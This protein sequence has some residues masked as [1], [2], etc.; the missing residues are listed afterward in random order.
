MP[1]ASGSGKRGSGQKDVRSGRHGEVT[2]KRVHLSKDGF[3]I[4]GDL[5]AAEA[6]GNYVPGSPMGSMQ[7]VGLPPKEH[8]EAQNANRNKTGDAARRSSV[9]AD[10]QTSSDCVPNGANG[11]DNLHRQIDVNAFKNTNVHRDSGPVDLSASVLKSLP[12]HD[13]LAI[14]MILMQMPNI[15]LTVIYAA[16]TC[17]TFVAPASISLLD[18]NSTMPSLVTVFCMDFFFMLIWLFLWQP[19]Q[20]TI[21]DLA[22]PVIALT[23]GGG[24]GSRHGPSRGIATS[25]FCVLLHHLLRGTRAH[26]YRILPHLPPSWRLLG[27]FGDSLELTTSSNDKRSAYVWVRSSLAIHILT[28]GIVRFI[29]E[30]Y[31][32][33][34]KNSSSTGNPDPEAGRSGSTGQLGNNADTTHENGQVTLEAESASVQPSTAKKRKKQSALVRLQQPLWAALASTKIVFIKEIELSQVPYE[35]VDANATGIQNLGNAPFDK[36]PGKIWITYIGTDEVCF[37]TS[38]LPHVDADLFLRVPKNNKKMTRPA[39]VDATKPFYVKVNDAFWQPTRMSQIEEE[40]PDPRPG[41]KWSGDIYGLRPS[42][43]YVCEFIDTR[44]DVA[45]FTANIRTLKESQEAD[46]SVSSPPPIDEKHSLQ[47]DSPITTLQT[48]I[49]AAYHKLSEEKSKLKTWRKEW[50]LRVNTLKRDSELAENQLLSAGNSDEKYKQKIRQQETQK[51]QAER[52]TKL[53]AEKLKQL[54]SEPA[55]QDKKKKIEKTYASEKKAFEAAQKDMQEA[56]SRLESESKAKE[57]EKSNLNSRRNKVAT[58]I[59]KVDQE[60]SNLKD[61]NKRGVGEA[62]RRNQ[63]RAK[64]RE[65]TAEINSNYAERIMSVGGDNNAKAE[66]ISGLEAQLQAMGTFSANNSASELLQANNGWNST[67]AGTYSGALWN[68]TSSGD[69]SSPALA[70]VGLATSAM[71]HPGLTVPVGDETDATRGRSSS[72]LSNG[73]RNTVSSEEDDAAFFPARTQPP[74]IP[75]GFQFG[76]KNRMSAGR[77]QN[78]NGSASGSGSGSGSAGPTSPI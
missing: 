77:P 71:W 22:K 64:W 45:I 69:M 9:G 54:D 3:A 61:A 63:E 56:K 30:W 50:K 14:L 47:P 2:T 65:Y 57:V 33:R 41:A 36:H 37:S 6:A 55:L 23:L 75:Q 27:Y 76:R 38:F 74:K 1:R 29:R 52:D 7:I 20:N 67:T 8:Y 59:A 60:I 78:G 5:K 49:D 40:D 19:I 62:D 26:W 13:T 15:V 39:G 73:S 68:P 12:V 4:H 43:K 48:S 58:R 70:S 18:G 44:S 32:R 31:L 42:S 10:S 35:C 51:A 11:H 28:Q 24:T 46:L 34:E 72:M 53:L 21:L 16:F 17:L 25:F 66:Y